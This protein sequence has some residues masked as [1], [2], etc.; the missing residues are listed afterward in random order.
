MHTDMGIRRGGKQAEREHGALEKRSRDH[1]E[2]FW[3][4]DGPRVDT[5]ERSADG[6]LAVGDG[7]PGS[8][9]KCSHRRTTATYSE[10]VSCSLVGAER[11]PKHAQRNK[12]W[13]LEA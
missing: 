7:D 5:N 3:E 2:G 8:R 1:S 10:R 12:L 13:G 9:P 6:T 11:N 4:E